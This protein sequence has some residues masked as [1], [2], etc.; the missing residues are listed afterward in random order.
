[1]ERVKNIDMKKTRVALK[2][3]IKEY[4]RERNTSFLV[5][6]LDFILIIDQLAST[7]GVFIRDVSNNT[8]KFL[9]W[10]STH[11]ELE[12]QVELGFLIS[13][14]IAQIY[15][16]GEDSENNKNEN[17]SENVDKRFYI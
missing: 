5:N 11:K 17:N 9:E 7:L 15:N 4:S 16:I 2:E 10:I 1:M 6:A 14:K 12:K 8:E 13:N 3:F